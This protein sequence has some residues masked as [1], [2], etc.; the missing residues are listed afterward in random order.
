MEHPKSIRAYLTAWGNCARSIGGFLSKSLGGWVTPQKFMRKFSCEISCGDMRSISKTITVKR[1]D[2][3]TRWAMRFRCKKAT[4]CKEYTFIIRN[5][6]NVD[7]KLAAISCNDQS[8]TSPISTNS[9]SVDQ[10]Q[11]GDTENVHP[12]CSMNSMTGTVAL[13]LSAR[14]VS[15]FR[16]SRMRSSLVFF[17]PWLT[18]LM[19]TS[20]FLLRSYDEIK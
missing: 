1:L 11:R 8:K 19:T 5:W 10:L 9:G 17:S 20:R 7:D 13:V 15:E 14:N 16:Y 3:F 12:E 18:A 2:I 4:A 6:K